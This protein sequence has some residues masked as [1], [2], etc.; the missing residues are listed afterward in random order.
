MTAKIGFVGAGQMGAPMVTR[1]LAAGYEVDLYARRP[2]VIQD[3]TKLG[4]NVV[5]SISEL[6][7]CDIVLCTLFSDDQLIDVTLG[8]GGL[9]SALK[10]GSVLV[11]HTTGS[12]DT[13]R[14]IAIVGEGNGV[15]VIDAPISGTADEILEGQLTVL[16]GGEPGQI[17]VVVPVLKS[18]A[19]HI[20]PTGGLGSA[21]NLKL[22]NN[23]LFAANLQLVAD[24]IELGKLLDITPDGL[25]N[26]LLYC[27]GGSSAAARIVEVGG[28]STFTEI[29]GPFL[30]KDISVCIESLHG[31]G[32]DAGNIGRLALEGP[33]DFGR[34]ETTS[35]Q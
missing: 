1:L 4:A 14:K 20:V 25:T 11:S 34:L 24:A 3:M 21:L 13:I 23:L 27:S 26:A 29:A 16:L 19:Q 30:R 2:E 28:L 8:E 17:D 35:P 31:L 7:G 9:V 18:Y 32:A 6:G 22:V 5:G 33:L 10:R 12:A 15:Q